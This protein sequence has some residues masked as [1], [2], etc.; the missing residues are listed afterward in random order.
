ML[1]NLYINLLIENWANQLK[2]KQYSEI[3]LEFMEKIEVKC[4]VEQNSLA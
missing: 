2:Q 4:S 3:S 1:H